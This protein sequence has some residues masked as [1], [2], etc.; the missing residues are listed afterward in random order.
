MNY[1]VSAHENQIFFCL[2]I[3]MSF[4]QQQLF[5]LNIIN[6]MGFGLSLR[7]INLLYK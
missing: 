4:V 2:S 7:I 1:F 6:L 3:R 5:G